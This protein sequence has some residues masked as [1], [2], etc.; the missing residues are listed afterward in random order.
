MK[1]D[2]D[3]DVIIIG[4]SYAGLSAA[5]SLGRSIRKVLIIDSGNPC[6]KSAPRSHNFITWDGAKPSEIANK[7]KDEVLF[8]PTV[9]FI[10]GTVT[11]IQKKHTG[12]EVITKK[13]EKFRSKKLLFATGMTDIMPEIEGFSQCW[14]IS[15]LHCPYCHGYEEKGKPTA[16]F[17]NKEQAFHLCM[18]LINLTK[19]ITLFTNGKSLLTDSQIYKLKEHN[20]QI[21]E[22]KISSIKHSNGQIESLCLEDKQELFF[23]VMY[24][25][26]PFK[27][28]C[29]LAEKTGCEITE[30]G[31]IKVDESK[32]TTIH[33]IFAAGDNT[34]ITRTISK[35]ISAGTIAG[36]MLNGEISLEG[37]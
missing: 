13:D 30:D 27:Q 33:G 1:E 6:N 19:E 32:R 16:V 22:K 7:A 5:M 23:P 34:S 15:I 24:A 8:Y 3:F 11:E 10:E 21:I 17:A 25:K 18:V 29:D 35:S 12:F 36:M 20:I 9:K 14:G 4:G 37:F 28:Q 2:R 26:L 31:F